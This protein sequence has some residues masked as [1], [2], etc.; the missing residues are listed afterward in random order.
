VLIS[1]TYP[2]SVQRVNTAFLGWN[3]VIHLGA[4]P[5]ALHAELLQLTILQARQRD[6]IH[7]GR[8]SKSVLG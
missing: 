5:H 3:I 4:V 8:D 6:R 7:L 1:A 2:I